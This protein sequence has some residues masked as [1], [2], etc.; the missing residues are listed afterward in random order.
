MLLCD[1]QDRPRRRR[2]PPLRGG[3]DLVHAG[4]RR[5][6]LAGA[7]VEGGRLMLLLFGFFSLAVL[8]PSHSGALKK[9]LFHNYEGVFLYSQLEGA[10]SALQVV[11]MKYAYQILHMTFLLS[12][13]NVI[14]A[15][16]FPEGNQKVLNK[17]RVG[18]PLPLAEG[19][20]ASH[21]VDHIQL[22]KLF[23]QYFD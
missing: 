22:L 23:M 3:A 2:E 11:S 1:L 12:Q 9:E 15:N 20:A 8:V 21:V 4:G 6:P 14:I 5:G 10:I 7:P 16:S 19:A 17:G 18:D 13:V